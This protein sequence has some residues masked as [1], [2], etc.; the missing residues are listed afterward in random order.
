[1][2]LTPASFCNRSTHWAALSWLY[3]LK[4]M[5]TRDGGLRGS[6]TETQ[7]I[8]WLFTELIC[9][10]FASRP[11]AHLLSREESKWAQIL[12]STQF[13]LRLRFTR[14]SCSMMHGNSLER[15]CLWQRTSVR[16]LP[17]YS[18]TAGVNK[19]LSQLPTDKARDPCPAF[20]PISQRTFVHG[21]REDLGRKGN[22]SPTA[23]FTKVTFLEKWVNR[24]NP[25]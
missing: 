3:W 23:Q 13:C 9:H 14:A 1:M 22:W 17:S 15:D 11:G 12:D 8:G 5:R 16:V 2:E 19:I 10:T 4:M 6:K 24:K 21:Q 20:L 25:W 7:R 18:R